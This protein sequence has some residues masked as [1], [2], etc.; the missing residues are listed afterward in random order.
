[1]SVLDKARAF[2]SEANPYHSAED[3][4]FAS[5]D[6]INK[7]NAGSWS[8]G[9]KKHKLKKGKGAPKKKPAPSTCG[10]DAREKGADIRCWDGAIK[11]RA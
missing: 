5:A 4:K 9:N 2:I 11:R 6:K 8:L 1:M 3:G 10:R 7:R